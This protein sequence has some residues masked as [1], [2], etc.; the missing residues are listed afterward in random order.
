M[1]SFM[2]A[3][4]GLLLGTARNDDMAQSDCRE[5]QAGCSLA[6][7][8]ATGRKANFQDTADALDLRP[9]QACNTGSADT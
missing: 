9:D 6:Q 8:G 7:C 1:H 3:M 4:R 5:W 2:R